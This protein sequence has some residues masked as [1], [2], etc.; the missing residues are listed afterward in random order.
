MCKSLQAIKEKA[1]GGQ[2]EFSVTREHKYGRKKEAG[3]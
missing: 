1:H 2:M 3:W